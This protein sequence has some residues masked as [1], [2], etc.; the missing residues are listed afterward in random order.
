M[1]EVLAAGLIYLSEWDARITP[2]TDGMCGSGTIAIE[3]A[4]MAARRAPNLH[5]K[6]FPFR[7]WLDHDPGLYQR[8]R[9]DLIQ[10]SRSDLPPIR[11]FDISRKAVDATM[12]NARKAGIGRFIKVENIRFED[13]EANTPS[14]LVILN[15][16]YGERMQEEDVEKLY[17]TIGDTLKHRY[18]GWKAGIISSN[19]PAIKAIRLH[20]YNTFK[21]INGKLPADFKLYEI[22]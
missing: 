22:F 4:L 2:F 13:T 15:P 14:G 5:R 21:L 16:P 18:K 17:K 7:Q 8:I 11:A 20:S 12:E 3:A 19:A 9:E 10:D 6:Y 1:S